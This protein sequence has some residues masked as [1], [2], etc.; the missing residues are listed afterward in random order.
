LK[1]IP[2]FL[3]RYTKHIPGLGELG[4]NV[5][6]GM[7]IFTWGGNEPA[8]IYTWFD[9]KDTVS[10]VSSKIDLSEALPCHL[11]RGSASDSVS[12]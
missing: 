8:V 1:S 11:L 2:D 4:G 7:S 3:V 9:W 10:L 5:L 6:S 12:P